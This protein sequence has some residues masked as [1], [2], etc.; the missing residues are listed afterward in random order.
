MSE[1]HHHMFN[2]CLALCEIVCDSPIVL[3]DIWR[4]CSWCLCESFSSSPDNR[5]TA[6]ATTSRIVRDKDG[7]RSSDVVAVAQD[8]EL[9]SLLDAQRVDGGRDQGWDLDSLEGEED[10]IS[11]G[12]RGIEPA[13]VYGKREPMTTKDQ[14]DHRPAQSG[15][16]SRLHT[17]LPRVLEPAKLYAPETT[18]EEL[19]RE[20]A[21]QAER[22]RLE[23]ENDPLGGA[24]EDDFGDYVRPQ[25][26]ASGVKSISGEMR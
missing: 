4:A 14:R 11:P 13:Q 23:V 3:R 10:V 9:E 16:R 6:R 17:E 24:G 20:E 7:R 5:R 18:I 19:A 12:Q 26:E 8:G 1:H 22:E 25:A 2:A 21:E 15:V